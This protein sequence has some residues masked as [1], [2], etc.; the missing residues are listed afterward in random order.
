[1]TSQEKVRLIVEA[2][3]SKH[4]R[5]MTLLDLHGLTLMTDYF[6]VCE[7][8]SSVHIRTI[9]DH[10]VE[11]MKH[12]GMRGIRVEGYDTAR[13]VLMDYQDVVAHVMAPEQR[14]YYDLESFWSDAR[15][16][17]I[18]DGAVEG[19]AHDEPGSV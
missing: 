12:A 19:L 2:A 3:D 14:A 1:M 18:V 6:F 13:W 9:T 11:T 8:T 15:R 5:N 4:A 16:L 10:I 17:L 7:G